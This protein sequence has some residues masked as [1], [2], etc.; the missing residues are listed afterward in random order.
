MVIN[1]EHFLKNFTVIDFL[2]IFT[3]GA[4]VTLAYNSYF[5]GATAPF[6]KF[7]ADQS[8]TLVF[9]FV[10]LAYLVG[11]LLQEISKPLDKIPFV[12]ASFHKAWQANPKV[13]EM[14]KKTFGLSNR[15][16]SGGG[17][18]QRTVD[19]KE[20]EVWENIYRQ[21]QPGIKE[22]KI[23]LFHAF[24]SMARSCSVAALIVMAMNWW[25]CSKKLETAD[26]GW[27]T[28]TFCLC[29]AALMLH[30]CRRFNKII[31]EY[32]YNAFIQSSSKDDSAKQEKA[33][34][35]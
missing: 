33:Q 23:P 29:A 24:A 10:F 9:Y 26:T 18:Q 3:P 32:S 16:N 11:I 22:N 21:T 13:R 14:Y 35:Q 4:L 20:N 2:G 19:S 7:F 34:Q 5:G 12:D 30:R 17:T 15:S 8:V 31:I 28:T 27:V 1:M 6:T 25:A